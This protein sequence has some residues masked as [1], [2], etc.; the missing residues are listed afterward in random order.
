[1]CL[2]HI[3][4]NLS[5]NPRTYM[6]EGENQFPQ[7]IYWPPHAHPIVEINQKKNTQIIMVEIH[8][9]S[10]NVYTQIDPT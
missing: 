8:E 4:G 10:Q 5:L 7:V 1:M 3:P 2:L 6:M 9:F